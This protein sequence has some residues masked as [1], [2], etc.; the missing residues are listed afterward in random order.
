MDSRK[1]LEIYKLIN[2]RSP[3]HVSA[4]PTIDD[5]PQGALVL[6]SDGVV[7]QCVSPRVINSVTLNY[8]S[9]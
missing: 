9:N 2:D 7:K 8:G 5:I 3:T 1:I 4:W 6:D